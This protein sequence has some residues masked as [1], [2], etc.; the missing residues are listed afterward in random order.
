M[1]KIVA[2]FDGLK[3][4]ESTLDYAIDIAGK[5]K[6][7]L[8]GL[9]LEDLAY[10]S[11]KIYDLITEEGGGMD[12]KRRHLDKKDEKTRAVAVVEFEAACKKADLEYIIHK[13]RNIAIQELLKESIYADL[14][15]IDSSETL[16][17]HAENAPTSFIH[18]L[19]P[20]VQCPVLLVPHEFKPIDKLILLFDGEPSS[21]HA[22]KMLSYTMSAMGKYPTEIVTVN[23]YKQEL[24]IP[25]SRLMKE[26]TKRHFPEA[27]Y[28]TLKGLAETEIID[29]LKGQAGNPLIVLGAY[30]RSRVSRWF[31]PSM[32]D[33]LMK[34]L[35]FP[36]FIAHNK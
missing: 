15:V 21:V 23:P 30:R 29:Y 28:T 1:K 26:F 35:K 14:V 20:D 12:T 24:H 10:H 19:L 2:A 5:N 4:S 27:S 31:R 18:D 9:F 32:A 11:Y 6:A 7:H 36:L 25:D 13:D 8:V 16:A 34:E 3:F 22:I 17:H 33:T